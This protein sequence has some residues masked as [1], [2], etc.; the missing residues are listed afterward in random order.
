[1]QSRKAIGM[2]LQPSDIV[3]GELHVIRQRQLIARLANSG[4][5]T[6][7]AKTLLETM[8]KSL[9]QMRRLVASTNSSTLT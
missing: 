4:R 8:E 9:E 1:M 6:D 3:E 5:A 2:R 7:K